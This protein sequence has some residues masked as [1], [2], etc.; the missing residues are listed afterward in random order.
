MRRTLAYGLAACVVGT[1]SLTAL[2][3]N[4]AIAFEGT[5]DMAFKCLQQY[6]GE[7]AEPHDTYSIEEVERLWDTSLA[8]GMIPVGGVD[9]P[10]WAKICQFDPERPDLLEGEYLDRSVHYIGQF[11]LRMED[12][13]ALP[14]DGLDAFYA[15]HFTAGAGMTLYPIDPARPRIPRLMVVPIDPDGFQS[16]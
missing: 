11:Q 5:D 13:S 14:A 10:G 15:S 9:L 2:R 4:E 3:Y 1:A 16:R 6:S 7:G 8:A 12:G